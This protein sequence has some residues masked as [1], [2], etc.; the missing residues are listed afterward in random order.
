MASSYESKKT[1]T[2]WRKSNFEFFESRL[3]KVT[4]KKSKILVDLGAGG[5]QF[6]DITWQFNHISVD[7][8]K[9]GTIEIVADLNK[10]LPFE[11]GSVDIVFLS[12]LLEHLPWTLDFLTECNRILKKD[13]MI[14]GTI[15]FL[16]QVHQEPYDYNR[17]TDY[18]LELLLEKAGFET[19]EVSPLGKPVKVYLNMQDQ[20]FKYFCKAHFSDNKFIQFVLS[21]IARFFRFLSRALLVSFYFFAMRVPENSKFT[22]G[23]GFVGYKR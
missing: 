3:G 20:F 13:G 17:Y 11:D 18:M 16:I 15:P 2:S 12:N 14:I 22:Q 8:E 19:S 5:E 23:Y 21:R 1:W 10:P 4:D 9:F 6:R 7:F